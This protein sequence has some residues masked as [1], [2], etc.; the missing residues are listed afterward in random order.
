MLY[1]LVTGASIICLLVGTFLVKNAKTLGE[2]AYDGE[3]NT[4]PISGLGAGPLL[5]AWLYRI[6][7]ALFILFG[8]FLFSYFIIYWVFFK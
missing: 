3:E 1:V 5:H 7:G 6:F 2:W 4:D 8:L